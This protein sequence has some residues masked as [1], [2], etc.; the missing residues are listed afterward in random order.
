MFPLL[1]NSVILSQELF[2]KPN[3]NFVDKLVFEYFEEND[4][5]GQTLVLLENEVS[6]QTIGKEIED[7]FL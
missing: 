1:Y 4:V 3:A 6:L 5:F 7:I 2:P